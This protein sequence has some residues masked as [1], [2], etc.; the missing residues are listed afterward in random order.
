MAY[1]WEDAYQPDNLCV[2]CKKPTEETREYFYLGEG[3]REY[4]KKYPVHTHCYRWERAQII[5]PMV[6]VFGISEA[7]LLFLVNISFWPNRP[8][9]E[10]PLLVYPVIGLISILL[11]LRIKFYGNIKMDGKISRYID[12]HTDH[13]DY[14]KADRRRRQGFKME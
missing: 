14:Y 1:F 9:M 6:L 8:Y 10:M 7:L 2:F 3:M 11:P 4:S 12:S 13:E 5:L